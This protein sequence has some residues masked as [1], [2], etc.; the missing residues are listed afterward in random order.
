MTKIES[1]PMY[2]YTHRTPDGTVHV[3]I[4]ETDPISIRITIGKAGSSVAAWADAVC[5][6]TNELL[7]HMDVSEVMK[8]FDGITT[9]SSTYT[10]NGVLCRSTPEAVSFA[11]LEYLQQKRKESRHG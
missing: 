1:Y 3:F 2:P 11:L 6:L 5:G 7:R 10:S 9:G 4:T 8:I